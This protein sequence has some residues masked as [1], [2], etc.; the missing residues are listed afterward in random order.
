M[1]L[2]KISHFEIR[3]TLGAGGMGVVYKAY[4]T[5]LHR[6][7]AVKA[8][9]RHI[10]HNPEFRKRFLIEAQ[11]IAAL[12]HPNIATIFETCEEG[13]DAYIV[14]E[15]VEGEE[16]SKKISNGKLQ[17]IEALDYAIQIAE[18]L[19]TA[20]QKGIVHRDIK[21]QNIMIT[22]SNLVKIMDFGLAK[23]AGQS[24]LT[25]MG[26]IV[27]TINYMSPEQTWGDEID[28][29]TDLWALGVVFYEM[30]TGKLPFK[31]AY[32]QAVIYS[33]LK[34]EPK[35]V[36]EIVKDVP[37]EIDEVIKNLLSKLPENRYQ[38]AEELLIDLKA[39]K[40]HV[41]TGI[42]VELIKSQVSV[43]DYISQS[44]TQ[45]ETAI[46][47][48]RKR[49]RIIAV[50]GVL[51][52][53]I[54]AF[55]F[56]GKDVFNYFGI[57]LIPSVKHIAVLPFE[58]IGGNADDQAFAA[59][60]VETMT[61]K[62]SQLEQFEG[63]LWVVPSNVIRQSKIIDASQ[64]VNKYA[65]NL[66]LSGSLQK[67]GAGYRV[68]INLIDGTSKEQLA[69]RL[70]DDQFTS[71]SVIQDE[72]V[73]KIADMLKIELKP[74]MK[75]NL[76]TGGTE[77]PEAYQS[78]LIGLGKLANSSNSE[79]INGAKNV[80]EKAIEKDS[81]FAL[82][83]V[84]LAETD[85][86]LFLQTN[87]MTWLDKA[88]QYCHRANSVKG[89]L[90]ESDL[91]IGQVYN[92]MG[93]Y[94]EA[95]HIFNHILELDPANFK[96]Y[97]GRATSLRSLGL[98][99]DAETMYKKAIALKPDYWLGY[100][101]L[102]NFYYLEGRYKEAAEQFT[103]IIQIAPRNAVAFGN[104]GG[105]YVFLNNTPKAV[106]MLKKSLEL[107]PDYVT[108]SNLAAVYYKEGRYKEAARTYEKIIE[109]N[110]KD[111][112]MW[113]YLAWSYYFTP[114]ER[115]K[116]Q[117]ANQR[118]I[119][120]AELQLKTNSRDTDLLCRLASYYGMLGDRLKTLSTLKLLESLKI[121]NV[122][123]YFKIG[124]TYEVWLKDREN[125]LNWIK[126]AL[127]KGYPLNELYREPSLNDLVLDTKFRKIVK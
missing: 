84:G 76:A 31:A 124:L 47:K 58:V 20:H 38:T 119:S 107:D 108:Y 28:H 118:A 54:G 95:E 75:K 100:E 44:K 126:I 103:K 80:F 98:S 55:I 30:L 26:A 9:A 106:E 15:F 1:T 12:N 125:A 24:I 33:I 35:A 59:G 16:L 2:D 92:R 86:R 25:K 43:A 66:I 22:G 50:T 39:I 73:I 79:D 114:D 49:N 4:D 18:G 27:G 74:E 61:S 94:S 83:Y 53:L 122:D 45:I 48:K 96:A 112:R 6:F 72:A 11:A 17:A 78:Y 127:E 41:E 102:G 120:L 23:L 116:A 77:N 19:K 69:S 109:L 21:S 51:L 81:S 36:S 70:I 90:S 57:E 97:R 10:A 115:N 88:I 113:G 93:K 101:S 71:N 82:A 123:T 104:L 52:L 5:K 56:K 110:N 68:T 111:Y 60:L 63:K 64:A 37:K 8:L 91:I 40:Q 13:D 87:E 42:P 65:V 14:M 85:Y 105:I 3:E 117:E 99:K 34:E 7:V 89:R 46:P 29:R 67:M 62:L 32:E 121:P